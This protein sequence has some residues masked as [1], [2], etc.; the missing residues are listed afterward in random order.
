MISE[1][2]GQKMKEHRD[3]LHEYSIQFMNGIHNAINTTMW[4]DGGGGHKT[5]QPRVSCVTAR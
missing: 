5:N 1:G 2:N 3:E 4:G